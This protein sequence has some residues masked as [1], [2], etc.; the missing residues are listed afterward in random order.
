MRD[1]KTGDFIH[2]NYVIYDDERKRFLFSRRFPQLYKNSFSY[3]FIEVPSYAAKARSI[4]VL[5]D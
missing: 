1:S 4:W 5:H 2:G 3:S